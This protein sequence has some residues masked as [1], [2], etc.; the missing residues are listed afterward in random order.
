MTSLKLEPYSG[1]S[2]DMFIGALAP[3]LG[4]ESLITALPGK[5]GLN[6]VE[7][8]FTDV[9]RS[10]ISCRKMNVEL[11]GHEPEAHVHHAHHHPHHDHDHRAYVEIVH[12][13]DHADLPAG[14]KA[15]AQ[16]MFRRLGEAEAE[17]HGI[18]LEK[19]HFHEVG[20][21]DSIIDLVGAAV[22]IDRLQPQAVFCSPICVGHGFVNTAH[23]KLPIPAPATQHLLQGMPTFPGEVDKEMTTP[24]GATIL[25]ALQPIFSLPTLIHDA[26]SLGAG[27]RDL[28]QPNAL[29]AS[30]CHTVQASSAPDEICLLQTNLDNT[31]AEDLG[32]DTLSDL[33]DAG[34]L[35]AWLTP[36]VMKKGRPAHKLEVLCTTENRDRL[37]HYLLQS[38][39]TLGVRIFSGCR[40]KLNRSTTSVETPFGTVDIK[41]HVLP[42]GTERGIPEYE[43]C[44]EKA[45]MHH[46]SVQTVREAAMQ[47]FARR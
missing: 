7:V 42:D 38:L 33:L 8:T 43:S 22:L 19:V 25:A 45:A 12:M 31:S 39:P 3:L 47:A 23:G 27:S 46:Q 44:R 26:T 34:A 41:V 29:R 17:M 40:S 28:A 37:S 2:G 36:I 11:H 6:G 4:A 16:D 9:I 10:T 15:L 35:D 5:L 32:A 21:E 18:S 24:S 13:I 20:A 14:A 1:I 30:L